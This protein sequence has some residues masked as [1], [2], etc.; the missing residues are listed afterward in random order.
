MNAINLKL[1]DFAKEDFYKM[2][3][4]LEQLRNEIKDSKSDIIK[5][6]AAILLGQTA[7]IITLIKLLS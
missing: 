2:D 6:V 7:L 3:I 4:K 1:Y 5:W